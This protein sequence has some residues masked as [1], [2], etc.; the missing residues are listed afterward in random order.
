MSY[1]KGLIFWAGY[2]SHKKFFRV[3][4]EEAAFLFQKVT[5]HTSL[6]ILKYTILSAY[7]QGGNLNEQNCL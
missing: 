3:A 2:I 1:C 4:S 5:K 6:H 7:M